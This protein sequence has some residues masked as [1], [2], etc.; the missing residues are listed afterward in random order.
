MVDKRPNLSQ[1]CQA[2][3]FKN[4]VNIGF[5]LVYC[6]FSRK[7]LINFKKKKMLM[8]FEKKKTKFSSFLEDLFKVSFEKNYSNLIKIH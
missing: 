5:I 8:C 1:E 3:T 4:W 6:S 7:V 2:K